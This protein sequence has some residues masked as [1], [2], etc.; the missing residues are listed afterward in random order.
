MDFQGPKNKYYPPNHC[1]YGAM[2]NQKPAIVNVEVEKK[3]GKRMFI[4]YDQV[5]VKTAVG[6]ITNKLSPD[7]TF[8]QWFAWCSDCFMIHNDKVAA[9]RE[10]E[11][12][13]RG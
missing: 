1:N 4:A 8:I 3:S 5:C 9:A 7:Y 6:N 11:K 2:C 10:V 13:V 12:N